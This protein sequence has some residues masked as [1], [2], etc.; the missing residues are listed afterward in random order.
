MKVSTYVLLTV[1]RDS[2]MWL[3]PNV[4]SIRCP[5]LTH[6]FQPCLSPILNTSCETSSTGQRP[7]CP[8]RLH[9]TQVY[10]RQDVQVPMF[11]WID[12][13]GM[14]V[15]QFRLLQ[16]VRSTVP[17]SIFFLLNLSINRRVISWDTKAQKAFIKTLIR[18]WNC[19]KYCAKACIF[20][21]A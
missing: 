9:R 20:T 4:S 8:V 16:Y 10:F 1:K 14:K 19:A 17:N 15:E 21:L 11:P 13:G 12:A 5:H 3:H 18:N 2:L 6:R 7:S